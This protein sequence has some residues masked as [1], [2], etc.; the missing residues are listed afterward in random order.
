MLLVVVLALGAALMYGV[1]D[2]LGGVAARRS[3]VFRAT[4]INYCFAAAVLVV[5][6]AI[7]GGVWSAPAVAG[8]LTG[9]AF[10][11]VGF[12]TFYAALAA[13]PIS[14][15]TPL[16]ALLSSAVP[17]VAALVLGEVLRPL[18]WVA[19]AVAIVGSVMIGLERRVSVRSL[20]PRTLM[21]A[22]VSG[23]GFGFATIALD[24]V[25]ADAALI[26]VALD[27]GIGVVVL[28]AVAVASRVS[29]PVS[30]WISL[31][32]EHRPAAGGSDPGPGPVDGT[33]AAATGGPP[34]ALRGA[35]PTLASAPSPGAARLDTT[36]RAV[37]LAAAAGLLIGAGN[38]LLM[39]ALHAGNVAVVA[40]LTNLYPVATMVLAW[41]VLRERLTRMQAAGAALAVAA[42]VMLGLA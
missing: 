16:I 21:L 1:A 24:R 37:A 41:V 4:T 11:L 32:D 35:T 3:T 31:L 12:V 6:V 10:A 2:F 13:G 40:V 14:L 27:T 23:L 17:V 20:R 29:A 42:S 30:R 15:V 25:P 5:A 18:A 36:G 8:G 22:V 19:I 7:T 28:L 33:R 34:R 26:P 38:A 9:G 39:F